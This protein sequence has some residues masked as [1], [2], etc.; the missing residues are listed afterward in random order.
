MSI[1]KIFPF[2][3][4][5]P[6][7]KKSWF[8]DDFF[9]GITI[10]V[11]LIP[12]GI[13]Y[14][15]I[16]GLPPIYG[17]YTA[18]IPQI[19]YAFLGTSRQLAIGP[20]A[21][22]SLIVLSGISVLATVGS[23]HFI[24]LAILLAFVVGLF[25]IAFGFFRL[26]FLVNFLSKPVISGFT[27]GSA[28]IIAMNQLGN[29]LGIDVSRT[30]LFHELV[31]NVFEKLNNFH[32]QSLV[33]GGTAIAI[34]LLLK[35]YFK[36]I[37]ASLV[38]VI[39]GIL[40]VYLLGLNQKG[41]SILGEIPIG[42]PEFKIPNFDLGLIQDLSGLAL[43]L[44]LIGFMEA[45]SIA[46]S[47]EIKHNNYKVK[48]NKELIALGFGNIIGSFFQTYPATG[49][50]ARTAVNDQA[51]A[52]TPLSSLI[53]AL[54]IAI[55]LMFLTPAFYYLPKA[56]LAAIIM[57][58]AYS[59][60]DFSMPKK[61]LSFNL[62]DLIILNVTLFVTIFIGIKE[63]IL[64]GVVLSLVMLIYKSTKPH[65][66]ILG[67]VQ[68]TSFYRNIKRFKNLTVNKEILIIRFD[69]QLHFANTTYFKDKLQE[70]AKQ[71]GQ[72]LKLI[73]IDGE[74]LNALD[75]SAIYALDEVHDYFT[76]LEVIV[77]FTGLKGPVRDALAHSGLI[78]KIKYD[79]CFMSIQ[80][81][82][83]SY[84]NKTLHFPKKYGHQEYIKQTN[85]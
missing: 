61:L 12:Q 2:L 22:D 83:D 59:L 37:P 66:A 64:F 26:G 82:I 3:D 57:V 8:K 72:Y 60:L 75:S 58:A 63:G 33:L 24:I 84:E 27:S 46:K 4:W 74:S 48:P 68:G 15:M 49:G 28:I 67:N 65:I 30:N 21:M 5:L 29:L 47:I 40:I 77:A 10:G 85:R 73:I 25:Q 35:K 6:N 9:A 78:K 36:K 39:L 13:A 53:A 16:A 11:M 7:Y 80:D 18:M 45:I 38:V 56:I 23:E 31:M 20:A 1:K 42:L 52:K 70:F 41:V 62:R 32:W 76:R 69:A 50:F 51:G 44:A 81:A 17:L 19:V 14:A 34:L 43:T 54:I 55:S 71:K 79:H